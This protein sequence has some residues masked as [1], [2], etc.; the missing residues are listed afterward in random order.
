MRHLAGIGAAAAGARERTVSRTQVESAD[1]ALHQV[2]EPRTVD[3]FT[4]LI[5]LPKP[6]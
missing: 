6:K 1:K 5:E 4:G 2:S 3:Q